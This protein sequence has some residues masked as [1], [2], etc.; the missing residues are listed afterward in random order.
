M[1]IALTLCLLAAAV[2][3]NANP[4]GTDDETC[5]Q[6]FRQRELQARARVATLETTVRAT[7]AQRGAAEQEARRVRESADSQRRELMNTIASLGR[8]I[9][10]TRRLLDQMKR[11]RDA[12]EQRAAQFRELVAKFRAMT[13][14]GMLQVEIRDGLML[15]KLPDGILF[16]PGKTDVKPAGKDALAK[17]TQVLLG[18]PGRKFQ[19]AGHT[20]NVPIKGKRFRS[21]WELSAARAVEVVRLMIDAGMPPAR[22]SAAGYA[23]QLPVAPNDTGASR[24]H[25]RRIE[26]VVVPNLDELLGTEAPIAR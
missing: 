8:D 15:L 1:R 10:E 13:D 6:L 5:I 24:M 3:A 22:L 25:N 14:A 11:A 23:D 12:A 4:C 17:V 21:N 7:S 18:F 2:P 26:I 19:V 20:D 9:D 16:N